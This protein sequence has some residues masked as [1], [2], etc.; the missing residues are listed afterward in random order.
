MTAGATA[1]DP[2]GEGSLVARVLFWGGVGISAWHLWLNTFGVMSELR[3]SVVHFAMFAAFGALAWPLLGGGGARGRLALAADLAIAALG[4]GCV[5]YLFLGEESFYARASTFLWYD[6]VFCVAAPVIALEMI[7]RTTG[8]TVPILCLLGFTYVT[9]WGAWLS[10][11]LRFPGLSV[12]IA[13]FRVFYSD[14]GMFGNIAQISWNLVAMFIIFG[15]FLQVSGAD[16]FV[17]DI[18]RAIAKRMQGG[19][20]FVAVIASA[21]SGTISGSAVA[22]V[23]STG[24]VTI[25]LMKRAGF[26]PHFA[27]GVETAASTGGG[28]LPPIMGA[29]AF[30]MAS[31]TAIPYLHIAAVSAI[32]ALVFFAGVAMGVR[33]HAKR[34]DIRFVDEE[35]PPLWETVRRRGLPFLIPFGVLLY[36]LFT[37]VGPAFAAGV[38]TAAVVVVSWLSDTPMGPRRILEALALGARTMAPTAVLLVGIGILISA[39]ATTGL[40]N[41]FS[42]MVDRWAGGN[43]AV[44]LVLIGLA[45]L[46]LGAALPV[47]ASYVVLATLSAPALTDMILAHA[48][49]AALVAGSI[50]DMLR[51]VAMLAAPDMT[52]PPPGQGMAAADAARLLSAIPADMRAQIYD[53]I[54]SPGA[55]TL[56]LLSAHMIIFW[57]SQD[58]NVTPPVCIPAYAAAAIA[59][60]S[61]IATGM[62]AWRLAKSLYFVPLIMAYQPFLSGDILV[63]LKIAAFALPGIYALSAAIEGHAEAPLTWPERIVMAVAGFVLIVPFGDWLNWVALAAVAGVMAVNLARDRRLAR[64]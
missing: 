42:L 5:F 40:G 61:P 52:L 3:A 34:H 29:G 60:A 45:S 10:G 55:A 19:P 47:T 9:L 13:L 48:A 11:M 33:I 38:A 51:M 44:A 30:I 12:E 18:G 50:P 62:V 14:D 39:V 1:P 49:N 15:A 41:V 2:R 53:Q 7:R 22:N 63:Q 35:A 56:A 23:T 17:L 37:G 25:P 36:L 24:A 54:L 20:G 43:L 28:I 27:A 26:K 31:V 6:W 4:I 8:I 64:G 21:L 57:L 32:P 58:S 16:R 46:V 59:Q